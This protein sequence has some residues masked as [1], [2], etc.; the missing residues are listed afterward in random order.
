M[1]GSLW[2]KEP[3]L[4]RRHHSLHLGAVFFLVVSV[5]HGLKRRLPKPCWCNGGTAIV[6]YPQIGIRLLIDHS[7]CAVW[8]VFFYSS[9]GNKKSLR[10]KLMHEI[11]HIPL[12]FLRGSCSESMCEI[13]GRWR[14]QR[15]WVFLLL[16]YRFHVIFILALYYCEITLEIPRTRFKLFSLIAY[17]ITV[18][19][20]G[21]TCDLQLKLC[22]R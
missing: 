19:R 5:R 15:R 8:R 1:E 11:T 16:L 10:G 4:R 20:D 18:S 22:G 3:L 12:Y 9:I 7:S 21:A 6:V 14:D 17:C 13:G 2:H